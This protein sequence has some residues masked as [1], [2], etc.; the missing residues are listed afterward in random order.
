M[1]TDFASFDLTICK[2][3]LQWGLLCMKYAI[4]IKLNVYTIV[5]EQIKVVDFFGTVIEIF[6][7]IHGIS[8]SASNI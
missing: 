4:Q 5:L 1:Y 8:M 6:G 2:C 3:R 7:F